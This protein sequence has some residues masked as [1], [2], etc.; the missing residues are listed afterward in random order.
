MKFSLSNEEWMF[1]LFGLPTWTLVDGTWSALSQIA[2]VAPESY[3]ISSYLMLA[4]TSGNIFPLIIGQL[5]R[6]GSEKRLQKSISTIL[7]L[8]LVTGILLSFVWST[9]VKIS[10]RST[11]LPLYILFF[12]LGSCSASS[13]VT[14]YMFVSNFAPK[15]TTILSTGMGLGS[16]IA[17]LLALLQGLLLHRYGFSITIYYLLLSSLYIPAILCF[18]KLCVIKSNQEPEYV[19]TSTNDPYDIEDDNISSSNKL[20]TLPYNQTK[21]IKEYYPILLIQFITSIFGYG[22]IPSI[23]SYACSKFN[24]QNLVLLLATSL[25]SVVDPMFRL[26]TEYQRFETI[27]ELLVSTILLISIGL[28]LIICASLPIESPLYQGS[29][30]ILPVCLYVSFGALFGYTNTSIF[31]YFK[32]NVDKNYIQHAYRLGGVFMQSGAMIGTFCTFGLIITNIIK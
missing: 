14:H 31:R 3:K 24:N 6:K 17:G 29:G 10:G 18:R 25:A 16:M 28:G 27:Q 8:G 1:L 26:F 2:I 9:N 7:G 15:T 30:G 23:I 13:N 32:T 19:K 5:L 12:V 22:I 20:I 21:F 4:L 11:S